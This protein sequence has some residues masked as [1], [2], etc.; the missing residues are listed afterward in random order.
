MFTICSP[1][2]ALR[3]GTCQGVASPAAV[4]LCRATGTFRESAVR[5]LYVAILKVPALSCIFLQTYKS[6][7]D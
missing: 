5:D 2:I 4:V 3:Y 6:G 1:Y 7:A